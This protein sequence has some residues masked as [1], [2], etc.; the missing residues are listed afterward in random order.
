MTFRGPDVASTVLAFAREYGIK[1]IV[2]GKSR[3]PWYR[4]LLYGSIIERLLREAE[5]IDVV[6]VGL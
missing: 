1:V 5:G 2:M 4:H 3:Q 6:I